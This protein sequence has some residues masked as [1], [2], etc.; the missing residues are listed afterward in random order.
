MATNRRKTYSDSAVSY[1]AVG[2]T[3]AADVL[4]FPPR[5]FRS[6]QQEFQ[7]GSSQE[8]FEAA[9]AALMT[10]GAQK[11]AH[12]DVVEVNESDSEGYNGL[13]F[14]E[15]GAPMPPTADAIEQLFAPDGTPYLS[16]G[17]SVVLD[18]VWTPAQV[19]SAHRVIYVIREER[20]MGFALG[21]LG[22][23]PVTGEELFTVEWRPDDTVWAVVRSVTA[24]GDGRKLRLLT[25]LIRLR[26][27][28]QLR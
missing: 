18:H 19:R 25:P 24:V 16:P 23:Y 27:F 26:Q 8:R 5:G 14:N 17:T 1:A 15:F 4:I 7:L 10:W 21:T 9:T 2:A 6:A 22:D 11:G 20:R 3:Q 13:M 28:L 12:V